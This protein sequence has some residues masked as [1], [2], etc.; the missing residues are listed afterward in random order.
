M[1]PVNRAQPA[2]STASSAWCILAIVSVHRACPSATLVLDPQAVA[3]AW[4]GEQ[5]T[6][7]SRLRLEFAAQE[8]HVDPQGVGVLAGVLPP[9]RLQQLPLGHHLPR[10]AHEGGQEFVLDRGE[11]HRLRSHR[12]VAARQVDLEL[13]DGKERG[14][15]LVRG[16]RGTAQGDADPCQ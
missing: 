11:M 5:I 6:G 14:V 12:H 2:L 8:A 9:D 1:A 16:A 7:A 3:D 10:I 15:R 13:P 4:L